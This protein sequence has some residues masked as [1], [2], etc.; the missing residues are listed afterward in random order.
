MESRL[1]S[2]IDLR[3]LILLFVLLTTV[4]TAA[5]SL[6]VAYQVQ[7]LALIHSALESNR[8]YAAKVASSIGEFLKVAHERLAYSARQMG[9]DFNNETMLADQATDLQ[10]Q[11]SGFSS[12]VI[13]NAAGKVRV[14]MPN[15]QEIEGKVIKSE[16]I[17]E[18]LRER[19]PLVS[20]AY[21]TVAGTLVVFVSEP[22]FDASGQYLGLVGGS[23][24]LLAESALHTVVGRHY[25]REEGYAYVVDRA[26]QF[27]FHPEHA[28]IGQVIGKN[29]V[30]DA[31]LRGEAGMKEVVNSRGVPM[32]AGY[33][34][35]PDSHW[36]VVAQQP[37]EQ[38][39][40]ALDSLMLQMVIGILPMSLLGLVIIWWVTRLITR[41][42]R[43]LALSVNQLDNPDS[44]ERIRTIPAWYFE[45]SSIRSA[46]LKGVGVVH[47]RIGWLNSQAQSDALTG[48]ANRRAMD[49]AL[50]SLKQ[51]NRHFAVLALDI[52]HFKRV[53]DT[54][55]HDVGDKTL[56]QVA[57]LLKQHS[58][59]GDLP[60]RVGG[61]EF[62]V[63]LPGAEHRA[64]AEA[65]ERLRA[66]IEATD[67][68]T[69]GA[70]TVS[71][72]VACWQ[73]GDQPINEVLKYADTLLYEAKQ[74][75]RN[76]VVVQPQA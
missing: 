14:A 51:N 55:G 42:L 75:G 74:R 64:A 50:A 71:L 21:T 9:A 69:V 68:E 35:V 24:D 16:G 39:L 1:S 12:I 41:P 2:A 56:R 36:G 65:A 43:L 57:Q 30:V 66:A 59:E 20:R 40:L 48:L 61:E 45:A 27:L 13:V 62:I 31:V 10:A 46:L 76:R 32:L 52:D 37:R 63:L 22:I 33:A 4:I 73:P 58:R 60:C 70:V 18:A 34:N 17:E 6:Y 25:Y 7:K 5:N 15:T 28:L 11:A 19:K 54:H 26:R 29:A 8:V 47:E 38:I 72:G 3:R 23:V 44:A 67:F 53:N 49:D